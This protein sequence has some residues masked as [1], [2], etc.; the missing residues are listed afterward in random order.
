MSHVNQ[1]VGYDEHF[2]KQSVDYGR[3]VTDLRT[4]RMALDAKYGQL[5]T[6]RQ[7]LQMRHQDTTDVTERIREVMAKMR[8]ISDAIDILLEKQLDHLNSCQHRHS[9]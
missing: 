7:E 8:E 9:A 2:V 1:V 3:A 5:S 6:E 4:R